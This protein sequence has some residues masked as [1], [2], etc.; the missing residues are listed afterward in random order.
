LEP[1]ND[2]VKGQLLSTQKLVRKIE[3]EKVGCCILFLRPSLIIGQAIEVEGE[4]DAVVRCCEILAEGPVSHACFDL[5][6]VNY[7]HQVVAS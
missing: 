5:F 3:F 4:K 1:N 7:F 6:V 2:L